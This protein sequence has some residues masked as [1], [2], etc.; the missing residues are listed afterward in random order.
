M[1][2]VRAPL[3]LAGPTA[4]GKSAV[5]LRLCK[6]LRAEIISVDSMQVYRG[7]DIGTAKPTVDEREQVRHHLIDVVD[8]RSGFNAAKFCALAT[9]AVVTIQARGHRPLFCGGTGLYFRAWLDG[10]GT[11]PP[12]DPAL[13]AQLN[14][15]PLPELMTELTEKDPALAAT[16]DAMN[17]RRVV[18]AVE[19]IRLTGQAFSQQRASWKESSKPSTRPDF[20]YLRRGTEDLRRRM[21][22]RVEQM[23]K[24]GWVKETRSLIGQGLL[25]NP[26]AMQ[27]IGYSQIIEMI[28]EKRSEQDTVAWVKIRTHQFAKRQST[29]FRGQSAATMLDLVPDESP[30]TTADRLA[31]IWALATD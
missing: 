8:L 30:Q 29:W 28:Q 1:S 4:V 18:R 12:A 14:Q 27:A 3:F 20:I 2:S 25:E 24:Q 9:E 26:F 10:L 21:D 5:A 11:P 13:R 7:M 15:I 17:R 6:S 19:V 23:F 31:E 22:A 16:I